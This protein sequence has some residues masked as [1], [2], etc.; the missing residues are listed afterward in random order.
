[1]R[2]LLPALVAVLAL[3]F[4]SSAPAKSLFVITGRG[5]GH[6]VGMSQWGAYGLARYYGW[7]SRQILAHYYRGTNLDTRS[8]DR[9]VAVLLADGRTSLA[10]GSA[11]S[12]TVTDGT[13]TRTHAA[14]YPVGVTKTSTGRIKV[15]GIKVTF[16]SPATFSS[17]GVLR[18]NGTR[19]RGVLRVSIVN[20]RLR[21]VNRVGLDDYVRGVVTLESPASWGDV[22]A[23]AALEAQAVAARSYALYT[24]EHGGGKCAGYLCPTVSDQVYGGY[25]G[26]SRN[27]REAVAASAGVVVEY[28]G[29]VAQTFFSSSSGGRTAA[30]A[31]VWNPDGVPYLQS[32]DD[33]ADLNAE[34]PNRLWRLRLTA[35]Q[36]RSRLGLSKTPNDGTVT[37]NSSDRVGSMTLRAPGWATVVPGGDSLRWRLSVKSNRFWLGVLTLE[38]RERRIVYGKA[39]TLDAIVRGV[40]K[41]VLQAH[42]YGASAW[43]NV[44]SVNGD[45]D[46]TL[47]PRKTTSYRLRA[48]TAT[49]SSVTV[50]VRAKIAFDVTQPAGAL[51]GIVRPKSLAGRT[52]TIQKRQANGWAK[53]ATTTVTAEGTFRANFNVTPGTYRAQIVPPSGSG[54][55]PGTSPALTVS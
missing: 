17:E 27:G 54:L 8:P 33:P 40:S 49:G 24:V 22:G 2:R 35:A 46:I 13:R 32:E 26:E 10:V 25:D 48:P 14:A 29:A 21:A 34:N 52:V 41:T 16:A 45:V 18:L 4:V 47:R 36:M 44:T 6:G 7:D 55:L 15:E 43:S 20:S 5:W 53:V 9:R 12:F 3:A 38:R 39:T 28:A 30:S 23:Q 31:D 42:P 51:R 1:M 50:S 37:R 11:S 19:Y